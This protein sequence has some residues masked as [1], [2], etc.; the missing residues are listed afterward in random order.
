LNKE[1]MQW[2]RDLESI[3]CI[4]CGLN[5]VYSPPDI[6][7]VLKSGKRQSHLETIPLC[8]AHHRSGLNND[9][10]VSRHPH[11]KGFEKRYGTENDLYEKTRSA[12]LSLRRGRGSSDASP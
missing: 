12:V 8:P 11:K 1:E 10:V 9:V 2:F 6:H 3:G 7:H 4:V 5:G